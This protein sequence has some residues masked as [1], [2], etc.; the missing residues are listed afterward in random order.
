MPVHTRKTK[1]TPP[2]APPKTPPPTT[3]AVAA[4]NTASPTTQQPILSPG[5]HTEEALPTILDTPTVQNPSVFAPTPST[6]PPHVHFQDTPTMTLPAPATPWDAVD[7]VFTLDV[8][9]LMDKSPFGLNLSHACTEWLPS[10]G[11]YDLEDLFHI[12]QQHTVVSLTNFFTEPVFT[13]HQNDFLIF[14]K[15]GELC[16]AHVGPLPTISEI[17]AT[18]ITKIVKLLRYAN[19]SAD[20]SHISTNERSKGGYN[21]H[22]KTNIQ[23]R[24]LVS[25]EEESIDDESNT[26]SEVDSIRH[27]N[28]TKDK[29]SHYQSSSSEEETD[30]EKR[31]SRSKGRKDKTTKKKDY[32]KRG[33]GFPAY[34]GRDI[35]NYDSED[36]ISTSHISYSLGPQIIKTQL[37][38]RIQWDGTRRGFSDY[39]VAIEGF[40]TQWF[41]SYLVDARFH[42][43]YRKHGPGKVIDHPDL[44]RNFKITRPQLEEAKVHMYGAIKQSTGKS[45]TAKKFLT[46][47]QNELDGLKVWIDLLRY[48]DHKGTKDVLESRL[49]RMTS[50]LYTSN[51][52]GGLA[53][54]VD[55]LDEAFSGL[56]E[57]G[58]G[59]TS[60]QKTHCLIN[61]LQL[62]GV[63][64][65]WISHC[66]NNFT[67]FEDCVDYLR[68]EAVR[69]ED[70]AEQ[71][72][73]RK[74]RLVTKK[75]ET[76]GIPIMD[77][78]SDFNS[79]DELGQ[80]CEEQGITLGADEMRLVQLALQRNPAYYVPKPVYE[81]IKAIMS[82]EQFKQFLDAKKN[83]EQSST[84]AERPNENQPPV[85]PRQYQ[86][87]SNANRTNLESE[88]E[89]TSDEEDIEALSHLASMSGLYEYRSAMMTKV[90]ASAATTTEYGTAQFHR[91]IFDT[92]ADTCVIG[93][94]WLI[95]QY[96]G[97]LV[98]LVGFDS[99]YAKKKHLK[100][101]TA[102]TIIEHPSGEKF[103][104]RIHQAV[105]NP[106]ACDTL[107]SE[108]QLNQGGCRIDSKSKSHR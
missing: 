67:R 58:N 90:V 23:A 87:D 72:G 105:H 43:L 57:L 93:M 25:E 53:K 47:H 16:K 31:N 11:I 102:V 68:D 49:V 61:N 82:T 36:R 73:A 28:S 101:C 89:E 95:T 41:S 7:L 91:L 66:R 44:P 59:Y 52:P 106:D 39:R 86:R 96:Y 45:N 99:V 69:R 74:A 107:L 64:D 100:L 2:K 8:A 88:A 18:W 21:G 46:R 92:G 19:V 62:S 15:F 22:P 9:F 56:E 78:N 77:S 37:P 103:L 38:G 32:L 85:T 83:A 63:N 12:S 79:M 17:Q 1:P 50:R 104:L 29:R 33:T 30:D 70:I 35:L 5:T 75:K 20:T 24:K 81:I 27:G 94:G 97:T 26:E 10:L 84:P 34:Q 76:Q 108:Y 80:I 55:D 42:E 98:N 14:L 3:T 60:R 48:L 54:Y 4:T 13:E 65:Y 40:Y 6:T 51:Y 71:I